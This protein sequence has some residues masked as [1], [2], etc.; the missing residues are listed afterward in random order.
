MIVLIGAHKHTH[1]CSLRQDDE[2]QDED[3]DA[4]MPVPHQLLMIYAMSAYDLLLPILIINTTSD[5]YDLDACF[6]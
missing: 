1:V 2:R 5:L 4:N 6:L 3:F